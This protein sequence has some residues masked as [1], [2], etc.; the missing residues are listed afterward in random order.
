MAHSKGKVP[1]LPADVRL[2]WC[3]TLTNTL[4]FIFQQ[5][6]S[7]RKECFI[8]M[9]PEVGIHRSHYKDLTTI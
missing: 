6:Q 7:R 3:P 5:R 8:T 2:C 9:T 1:A 4:A